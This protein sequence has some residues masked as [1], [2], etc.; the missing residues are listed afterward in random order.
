MGSKEHSPELH[1]YTYSQ[2]I[3][4]KSGKNPKIIQ[5]G[6]KVFNF[7]WWENNWIFTYLTMNID[8]YIILK[9]YPKMDYRPKQAT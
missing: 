3:I 5:W 1:P 9:K 2:L 7:T 8:R 4:S 6:R